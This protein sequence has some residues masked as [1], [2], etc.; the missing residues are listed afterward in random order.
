[1]F[2]RL[3]GISVILLLFVACSNTDGNPVSTPVVVIK[4]IVVTTIPTP[5]PTKT[6]Q[7]KPESSSE[8]IIAPSFKFLNKHPKYE[9][10]NTTFNI[11]IDV[12]GV[13][14]V[15]VDSIP[16][17]YVEHTA[18]VFAEFIDNNKDGVLFFCSYMLEG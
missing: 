17:D 7:P 4:E 5:V 6:P 12:F 9:C 1:M 11:F 14:I 18:K 8:L 10:L 16:K 15:S 2:K 13:Y 3:L